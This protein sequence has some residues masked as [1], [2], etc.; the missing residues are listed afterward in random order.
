[1]RHWVAV[2]GSYPVVSKVYPMVF[3]ES[4]LVITVWTL[5]FEVKW[6]TRWDFVVF[7]D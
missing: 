7:R 2:T 6:L 1:M 5:N 4:C 3:A